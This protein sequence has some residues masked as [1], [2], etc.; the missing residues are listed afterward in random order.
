MVV[1]ITI[2]LRMLTLDDDVRVAFGKAHE[3][4]KLIAK[5]H[6]GLEVLV[7]ALEQQQESAD[8]AAQLCNVSFPRY[9]PSSP[10]SV[11]PRQ[12]LSPLALGGASRE[13]TVNQQ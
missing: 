1:Q 3:H 12:T 13:R 4:A 7:R 5:E 2:L 6:G 9:S 10:D 11:A 8:A